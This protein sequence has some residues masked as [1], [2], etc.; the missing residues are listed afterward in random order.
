MTRPRVVAII[1]ARGGSTGLR[2]K[3]LRL[4]C[5]K[6]LIAYAIEPALATPAIDRVIVSTDDE[7]IAERA[8]A[9][10]AEAP[11]LRPPE[12]ATALA[13]TEA[14]LQHCV[15]W[16]D[17]EGYCADI[18]VFLTC[19]TPF[20][21]QEWL[22]Q[23]VERLEHDPELETVFT[24]AP[25]HKNF[26]R[27]RSA[28]L[29]RLAPDIAYASRQV[30]EPLY[31]EDTGIATATRADVVRAGRRIGNRVEILVIDDDRT[32]IDIHDAFDFWLAEHVM[33]HWPLSRSRDGSEDES[34]GDSFAAGR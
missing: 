25:T 8:R 20:R 18:V 16:L 11:F 34:A 26:W 6:P 15:R 19:T 5:G 1:P 14:A 32:S 17:K 3:N 30:R 21:R 29:E 2:A 24:A 31:R 10:G 27:R 33:R 28:G 23:V 13:T 9:L 22:Q 12:L 7:R 4:L